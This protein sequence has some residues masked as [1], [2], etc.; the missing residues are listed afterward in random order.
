MENDTLIKECYSKFKA[1]PIVQIDAAFAYS[2]AIPGNDSE[3]ND[4]IEVVSG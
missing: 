2:D 4:S 1:L 3:K